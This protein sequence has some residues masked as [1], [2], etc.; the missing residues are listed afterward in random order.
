MRHLLHRALGLAAVV[1]SITGA[2][3]RTIAQPVDTTFVVRELES[4][5]SPADDYA[6]YMHPDARRLFFTSSRGGSS[7]LYVSTRSGDAWGPAEYVQ[8]RGVNTSADDGA[9]VEPFPAIAQLYPLDEAL[10]ESTAVPAVAIMTSGRRSD[11]EGD[12]DL[13]L[14][15][16]RRDGS[17]VEGPTPLRE[18]NTEGWESQPT[19]APDGR[20]IIFTSIRNEGEGGMDLFISMRGADGTYGAARSLGAPVNTGGNELSPSIAPDGRTLFF[21]SDGHP[22]FGGADIFRTRMRDD[23]TWEP[24]TNLGA[25]VNTAANEV[26]FYDAGRERCLFA[27]DRDGGLGGLD[28]YEG[29]PNIFAPGYATVHI[30]MRDTTTHRGVG[31]RMRVVET[32][33]GGTLLERSI[34]AERGVDVPM[35]AGF[36]YRVVISPDGFADTTV[37]IDDLV[38]ERHLD[39][40]VTLASA[41]PPPPPPPTR[42]EFQLAGLSVPLFV[43]GYYRLNMPELLED[44]RTRQRAGGDLAGET[45]IANVAA[46]PGAYAQYSAMAARVGSIVDDFVA[47]ATTEDL[48]AFRDGRSEDEV[49]EITVIGYADPRPIIGTYDERTVSFVD[50]DGRTHTVTRGDSLDNLKLAGLRAVYAKEYLD[51]R[52]RAEAAR[53]NR[54]YVDLADRGLVRWRVVSGNV[55]DITGGDNLAE[56]RRIRVELRRAK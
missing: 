25:A 45:Y 39:R 56:K 22:G 48:P 26:F 2:A 3:S 30:R 4:I 44:L 14:V 51:G 46:D 18:V 1:G 15:R 10:A 19:I 40:S 55:D 9:L 35:L 50:V 36:G 52:F 12:A 7:N 34:D 16:L 27:S 33:R 53:G 54:V 42:R 37:A 13:Y 31:G 23:G 8:L 49:L 32:T 5:N 38:A 43:S 17:I 41:P 6:P 28:I 29:T 20:F 21:A 24:P 47:H 11:S